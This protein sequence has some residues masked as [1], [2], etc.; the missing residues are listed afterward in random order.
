MNYLTNYYKNLSEQLQ[1]RVNVLKFQLNEYLVRQGEKDGKKGTWYGGRFQAD[2]D[3]PQS[4]N[5]SSDYKINP[6]ISKGEQTEYDWHRPDFDKIKEKSKNIPKIDIPR[7]K[8]NDEGEENR[9]QR[10]SSPGQPKIDKPVSK[11]QDSPF[12][13]NF[14]QTNYYNNLS[15]QLQER[16]NYLQHILNEE[17]SRTVYTAGGK[18]SVPDSAKLSPEEERYISVGAAGSPDMEENPNVLPRDQNYS[19]LGD[20]DEKKPSRTIGRD[21]SGNANLYR[22]G[23]V[24]P[25]TG[26]VKTF[27]GFER[28]AASLPGTS[29][30]MPYF[31]DEA[32]AP[33]NLGRMYTQAYD[34]QGPFREVDYKR[35]G[36]VLVDR[37]LDSAARKQAERE[38]SARQGKNYSEKRTQLGDFDSGGYPTNRE[39]GLP[40]SSGNIT[41]AG[42][43][44]DLS[45]ETIR[46]V[47]SEIERSS[48][49]QDWN[50]MTRTTPMDQ[51]KQNIARRIMRDVAPKGYKEKD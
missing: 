36:D 20:I 11:R 5:T 8:Q 41:H 12:P 50:P 29:K 27:L 51:I 15:K 13:A 6:N 46:A 23:D 37:E 47:R 24:D 7:P 42:A 40:Y 43:V 28:G 16:I 1:E 38:F 35:Q 14:G 22:E 18:I 48:E 21:S 17:N 32:S 26:K 31:N 34:I 9:T 3:R 44:H 30:K 39:A 45:P 33:A 19:T 10:Y 25:K 4:S 49:E 2:E